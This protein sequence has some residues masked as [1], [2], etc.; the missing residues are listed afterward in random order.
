MEKPNYL[1]SIVTMKCPRCRTGH[2]FTQPNPWRLKQVTKMPE[3]CPVC[4]QPFE[5]EVGFWYG[6][7]YVSYMLSFALSVATFV[8]WWV[9]V[10]LST[11][12]HRFFLWLGLN[13]VFLV[14]MQPW[15]M[16]L[17][18]VLWLYFFISY[19][20]DYKTRPVKRFDYDSEGYYNKEEAP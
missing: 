18:R 6:T 5:L 19:D 15:I 1:W 7:G 12:D 10:G 20:P 9:I 11:Q 14:I 2:M 8:A 4:G 3:K 17:S 13:A 16:R